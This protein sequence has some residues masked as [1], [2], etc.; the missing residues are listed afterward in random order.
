MSDIGS[1][2]DRLARTRS[3]HPALHWV[4]FDGPGRSW[5]YGELVHDIYRFATE[6]QRRGVSVGDRVVILGDNSPDIVRAWAAVTVVGAVAVS[7]NARSTVDELRWYGSHA[8]PVG[9]IVQPSRADDLG[10]ANA[11]PALDDFRRRRCP[12]VR[13]RRPPA[14]D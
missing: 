5:T 7:L 12:D 10:Q 14:A 13:F 3:T 11:R 1:L 2:L 6:L 8:A 4:P 9:A